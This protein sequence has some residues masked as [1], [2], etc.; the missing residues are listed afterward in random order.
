MAL[1][2]CSKCGKLVS[3]RAKACPQCGQP[4][5]SILGDEADAVYCEECGRKIP[6]GADACPNC[7]CPVAKESPGPAA[8]LQKV[9]SATLGRSSSIIIRVILVFALIV[10]ISLIS[11]FAWNRYKERALKIETERLIDEYKR[12]VESVSFTMLMGASE[13]DDAGNT[14]A[15]VWHNF[16]YRTRDAETDKFI[17]PDRIFV[18]DI[19]DALENLFNDEDFAATISSIGTNQMTVIRLIRKLPDPP[20]GCE[21]A[22]EALMEY[23]NAYNK[24][25]SLVMNPT[26]TYSKFCEDF[27]DYDHEV[28]RCYNSMSLYIGN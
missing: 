20:E 2:N 7:G 25:T 19:N 3:D 16:I 6:T 28:M 22:Y 14:I 12:S 1:I 26:G 13:A 5:A 24:F 10:V 15:K 11:V 18:D 17:R 21:A 23:Y 27:A 9:Q 4:I 8:P